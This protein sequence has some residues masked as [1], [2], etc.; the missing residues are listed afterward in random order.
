MSNQ[1][2]SKSSI[3]TLAH[4]LHKDG[5]FKTFGECL[6]EAWTQSRNVALQVIQITKKS[7]EV[8]KRVVSRNWSYFQ[9]AKGNGRPTPKGLTLF[10]D[11]FK[12]AIG[13]KNCLIST[14]NY[15]TL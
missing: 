4:L 13:K 8:S 3:F 14:Y 10:A 12:V 2:V 6:K 11:I 15:V 1:K 5:L 7:G 9:P